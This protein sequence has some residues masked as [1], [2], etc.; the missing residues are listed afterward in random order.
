[1]EAEST[2][3]AA[4]RRTHAAATRARAEPAAAPTVGEPP[5]TEP[6]IEPVAMETEEPAEPVVEPSPSR[7]PSPRL[8]RACSRRRGS[9]ATK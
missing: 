7:R 3:A 2:A 4:R 1:M 5:V 8:L 6:T 9:A